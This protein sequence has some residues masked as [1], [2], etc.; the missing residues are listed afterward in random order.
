MVLTSA[1]KHEY[2][3]VLVSTSGRKKQIPY[4]IELE[5]S[6]QFEIA[7]ACEDYRRLISQLPKY[8][9]GKADYLNAIVGVLCESAKISM[10]EKKIHM[11]PWRK[12]SF[13]QMK[14]SSSSTPRG[15]TNES[16]SKV[17]FL[18]S[19]QSHESCLHSSA[20]PALIVA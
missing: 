4:L 15:S 19:R 18:P 11:G 13:M 1:G 2:I 12:R 6:D 16:S 17:S 10:K 5:F 14:W 8:Y 3:E 9:I 20:A 7:K